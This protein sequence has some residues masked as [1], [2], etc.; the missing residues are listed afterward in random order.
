MKQAFRR[1]T[2]PFAG[3]A[4]AGFVYS[5]FHPQEI[6]NFIEAVGNHAVG[7]VHDIRAIRTGTL[8]QT[9]DNPLSPRDVR[10]DATPRCMPRN[11]VEPADEYDAQELKVTDLREKGVYLL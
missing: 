5:A 6:C 10:P 8:E 2:Y 9:S 7:L 11:E 4:F 3:L 1:I